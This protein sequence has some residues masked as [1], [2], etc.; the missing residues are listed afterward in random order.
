MVLQ[1]AR[2]DLTGGGRAFV[3]QH[4][5][6]HRL[7]GCRQ[8]L[9]RITTA[10]AL[11]VVGRGLVG[12]L[13]VGQ[14][15]VGGHHR[16]VLGQ[17]GRRDGHGGIQQ[18]ARVVAQVQHQAFEV[19]LLLVDLF[20]LA[21]KVIDRAFLELRQANPG[22]ARLDHLALD[23]LGLDLFAGDGDRERAVL[24]LAEDGERDL[25][26]GLATHALD[27]VIQRQAL[28]GGFIDLGDQIV[29]FETSTE[30]RRPFDGRHDLDQAVFLRDL[31]AHAHE[32]AGRALAEFLEGLLVEILGVRVQAGHHAGD[33]VGDELL[34]IHRLDVIGLDQTKH[35]GELLDFLKWQ[36]CHGAARHRLQ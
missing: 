5:Q 36:R 3:D 17:E 19:G 32:A 26:A 11:V 24:V 21:H 23:G 20:H 35:G 33:G 6:R 7:E 27:G 34:V 15:A 28:D 8:A 25:G 16:H 10:P 1:C 29:G 13:A 9:E 12:G 30:G 18:A 2:H 14:L 31:D 22:V 4:H